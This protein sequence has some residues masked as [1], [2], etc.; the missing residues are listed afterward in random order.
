[1][2]YD[3]V[4][5]QDPTEENLY[6]TFIHKQEAHQK[7]GLGETPRRFKLKRCRYFHSKKFEDAFET[8]LY[9][10]QTK[11]ADAA[12]SA[13]FRTSINDVCKIS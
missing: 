10:M 6:T 4:S 12:F 8:A 11:A 13:V 2:N 3:S 5:N 7:V 9:L 1:M